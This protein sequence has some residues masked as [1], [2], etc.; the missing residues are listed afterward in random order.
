ML[1]QE[2]EVSAL[3]ASVG[4]NRLV[5]CDE[6]LQAGGGHKVELALGQGENAGFWQ[7]RVCAEKT[8]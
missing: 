6:F 7:G 1:V 5:S 4:F 8:D 2:E 3:G